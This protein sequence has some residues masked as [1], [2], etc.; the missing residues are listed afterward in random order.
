MPGGVR[1]ARGKVTATGPVSRDLMSNPG[2][3]RFPVTATHLSVTR[4]QICHRPVA[5]W[6]GNLSGVLTGQYRRA[7]PQAPGLPSRSPAAETPGAVRSCRHGPAHPGRTGRRAWPEDDGGHRAWPIDGE[8]PDV[9]PP[10]ARQPAGRGDMRCRA[11][12]FCRAD[13]CNCLPMLPGGVRLPSVLLC[14]L[15]ASGCRG[16]RPLFVF[17]FDCGWFGGRRMGRGAEGGIAGARWDWARRGAGRADQ[18]PAAKA[19]GAPA[20]HAG[21]RPAVAPRP[22]HREAGLSAPHGTPSPNDV[23]FAGR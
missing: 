10:Y 15:A 9:E 7:H 22:G 5:C 23:S 20:G 4:C 6:P 11:E 8:S 19:A 2:S 13:V 1:A 21:H 18:A 12:R 16:R 14:A 3:R 17:F